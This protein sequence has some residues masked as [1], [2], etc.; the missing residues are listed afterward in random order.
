MTMKQQQQQQQRQQ[1]Q[2]QLA[3]NI[4]IPKWN[5]EAVT[6]YRP[7]TTF[8]QDFSIS[9]AFGQEAVRETYQRVFDEWREDIV[10][11]AELTLVLNHKIWQHWHADDKQMAAVYND[12]WIACDEYC[13]DHFEGEDA[14][15]YFNVTD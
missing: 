2:K 9:D 10:H 12:L 3:F 1:R 8:W 6:G 13:Y 4:S 5:I 14:Q 11:M 15:Y 7:K